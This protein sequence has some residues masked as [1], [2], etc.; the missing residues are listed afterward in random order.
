MPR[1]L[2]ARPVTHYREEIGGRVW[3]FRSDAACPEARMPQPTPP[4]PR[5]ST[6]TARAVRI[7]LVLLTRGEATTRDLARA[8][9]A[10]V[11]V[12][13]E[14]LKLL[15]TLAPI[16]GRGE[17]DARVWSVG[18][19]FGVRTLGLLDRISLQL[20]RDLAGFLRGTSLEQSLRDFAPLDGVPSRYAA[21]IDRKLRILSEPARSYADCA[22]I[23]DTVLDALLRERAL[24]LVY[25]ATGGTRS[26]DGLTP[27]SLVL[28]R[29][30]LYLLARLDGKPETLRLPIERIESAT[31]GPPIVYPDDWDPD[32][33]LSPWFG[34]ISGRHV[35]TVV[36]RFSAQVRPYVEARQ[37][38]PSQELAVEADGAVTLRMR[39]GGGELVRFCLEWGEHCVVL[40]PPWLREKVLSEL[41]GALRLYE[42]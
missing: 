15:A 12:V 41:R 40:E 30:A 20:G 18:A 29:R 19:G 42:D 4:V 13:R 36:L 38:H 37:W 39:T 14:D 31:L 32:A 33:A 28:Y 22:D 27:L 5:Q 2:N 11:R 17:R 3:V 34:I 23:L 7:L 6:P 16:E 25:R 9:D 26:F 21:H 10:S 8:V 1:R 24:N 35:E